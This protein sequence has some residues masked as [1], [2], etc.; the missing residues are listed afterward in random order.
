MDRRTK[1]MKELDSLAPGERFTYDSFAKRLLKFNGGCISSRTVCN[2]LRGY[3]GIRFV[4][5][6]HD[7]N[8]T[9]IYEAI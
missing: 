6:G 9:C 5:I 4:C 2:L 1:I 8:N 7:R 3:E